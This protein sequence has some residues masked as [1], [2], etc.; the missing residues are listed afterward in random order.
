M[1]RFSV[2]IPTWKNLACLDLAYRSVIEH[3]ATD[4]ELIIFFNEYDKDC[5]QWLEGKKVVS[6]YSGRNLGVCGAVNRA[7]ELMTT[8]YICF[9]NDDMY[10]LPG[11]DV[12]LSCYL[13]LADKLW[14]SGTTVEAGKATSCYIGGHDYGNSPETFQEAR[15]L[16]EHERLM[17]PYN[18]VSTWTPTLLSRRDW[19]TIGGFDE[20]YFPGNG[21]DPD[22]A[23]KMYKHGCRHF[24]GVGASLMYHFSRST[25]SRFDGEKKELMDTKA[26]FKKK[27]GVSQ[28]RFLKKICRDMVIT[29]EF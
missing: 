13:G 16:A 11:W 28:K 10:A 14:L 3:S 18:M 2:I 8:D 23:M 17:R 6:A 19:E 15:L 20:E 5:E 29:K 7:S 24:I 4:H 27:W 22:L 1:K 9:M 25:I 26:Y 12:A 21:S